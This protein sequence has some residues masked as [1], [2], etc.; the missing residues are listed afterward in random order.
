[1]QIDDDGIVSGESSCLCVQMGKNL[2]IGANFEVAGDAAAVA[3][4]V[5]DLRLQ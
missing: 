5:A 2:S 3:A 1:M 4:S